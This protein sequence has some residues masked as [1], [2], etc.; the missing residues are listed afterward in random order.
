MQAIEKRIAALEQATPVDIGPIFIHFVALETKDAEIQRIEKG[1]KVWERQPHE[2]VQE[3]KDRAISEVPPPK[4]G[5]S[6]V[7]LCY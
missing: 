3:L 5:C 6:L 4:A 7:F 2:T 1:S